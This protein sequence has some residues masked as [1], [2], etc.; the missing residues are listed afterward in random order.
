MKIYWSESWA[1]YYFY[2]KDKILFYGYA[3]D[4]YLICEYM[5]V[6]DFE[7]ICEVTND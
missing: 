2:F 6:D 3:S 7:F 4:E 1:D 5:C